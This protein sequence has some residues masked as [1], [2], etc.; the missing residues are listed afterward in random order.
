MPGWTSMT[1]KKSPF[2]SW[3]AHAPVCVGKDKCVEP[4][5]GGGGGQPQMLFLRNW[6]PLF[7]DRVS[8]CL[9]TC[10]VNSVTWPE[11][12]RDL[13]VLS[14]SPGHGLYGL[15]GVDSCQHVCTVNILPTEQSSKPLT[16]GFCFFVCLFVA[17][18]Y[19]TK[20]GLPPVGKTYNPIGKLWVA[21][22]LSH[23]NTVASVGP[24]CLIC[25]WRWQARGRAQ[26]EYWW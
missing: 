11:I 23:C 4:G 22:P 13:P 2:E 14:S 10:Q 19:N 15:R 5:G 20:H 12:P 3:L 17:C 25:W 7:W 1:N 16:I 6:L 9:E 21:R 8:H 24:S 26:K 18:L